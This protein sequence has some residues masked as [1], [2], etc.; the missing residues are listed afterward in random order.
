[1]RIPI[2]MMGLATSF[3]WAILLIFAAT[4]ISSMENMKFDLAEAT[5]AAE[6]DQGLS[7]RIPL[8]LTNHGY[9]EI[10]YFNIST[11]VFDTLGS[12]LTSG[13]TMIPAVKVGEQVKLDH[14]VR[15][16]VTELSQIHQGI[17][18]DDT[19]LRV[20]ET[21]SLKAAGVIPVQASGNTSV[22]WGAPL[23][24]FC[25]WI[26]SCQ[27]FNSTHSRIEFQM[28]FQN[29]AAFSFLGTIDVSIYSN[30]TLA[31]NGQEVFYVEGYSPY[32][33]TLGVYVPNEAMPAIEHYE[34]SLQTPYFE[35][36]PVSFPCSGV[37]SSVV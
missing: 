33:G 17:L 32:Q 24:G 27:A 12:Q 15:L 6:A 23:Y 25:S 22:R 34:V 9:Y 35:Y 29:H 7:L 20:R 21:V 11:E 8:T 14:D 37:I 28:S 10:S 16:N 18:F 13:S 30:D 36:G 1:M 2:R 4:A 3:F 19:L 31:G 5:I 26:A